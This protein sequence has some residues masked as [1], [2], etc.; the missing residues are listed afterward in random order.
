MYKLSKVSKSYDS[1]DSNVIED[2]SLEFASNG[3]VFILGPSGCGKTTLLNLLGGLDKYDQGVINYKEKELNSFNELEVSEYRMNDVGFIFQDYN[4]LEGLNVESNVNI[5]LNIQ[6]KSDETLVNHYL[7]L[8]ELT[9]LN[10]RKVNQLSGGQQQRVAIARALVKNPNVLLC[11]EPTGNLDSNTSLTIMN[12]LK[13]FSK[14]KL[15]IVVS[16]DKELSY[17]YA[18]RI[19]ELSDGKVVND[20]EN[21]DQLDINEIVHQRKLDSSVKESELTNIIDKYKNSGSNVD[22]VVSPTTQIGFDTDSS[23]NLEEFRNNNTKSR[24]TW[25]YFLK[26]AFE[27]VWHRKVRISI[28][29]VVFALSL[30]FYATVY[31]LNDYMLYDDVG[32]KL[33]SNDNFMYEVL[34]GADSEFDYD[35]DD[36]EFEPL[37]GSDLYNSLVEDFGSSEIHRKTASLFSQFD[38][39]FYLRRAEIFELNV[40]YDYNNLDYVGNEITNYNDIIITDAIAHN[41][42][43]YEEDYNNY[44]NQTISVTESGDYNIDYNVVGILRTEYDYD[45]VENNEFNRA[46]YE[47]SVIFV[48]P[49]LYGE[50][51]DRGYSSSFYRDGYYLLND[52]NI[53]SKVRTI[54]DNDYYLSYRSMGGTY[55]Q[56]YEF[57]YRTQARVDNFNESILQ[58]LVVIVSIVIPAAFIYVY[59]NISIDFR[60]KEI[61]ILKSLGSSNNQVMFMFLVQSFI[62]SLIASFVSI[63]TSLIVFPVTF[64]A[65]FAYPS[66]EFASLKYTFG[67]FFAVFVLSLVISI[68]SLV[69]PYIKFNKKPVIDIIKEV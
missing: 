28:I 54:Y 44:I 23:G 41:Y 52:N 61:G 63:L 31:S 2:L 46:N 13:V 62:I 53:A 45:S 43:G 32:D 34:H 57:M 3:L 60:N 40:N 38:G 15:V 37:T 25:N 9:D 16:H 49:D 69:I 35:F 39:V 4:L 51:V 11:D 47:L 27:N 6:S 8:L 20:I 36:D 7:D 10:K 12:T 64:D 30:S 66:E 5:S 50:L 68:L 29:F 19:I 59:I 65:F 56:E 55:S 26:M 14:N 48:S 1:N 67:T 24:G 58:V 22:I 33:E 17:N 21:K 42:F 18:D